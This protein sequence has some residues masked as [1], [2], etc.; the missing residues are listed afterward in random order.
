M[1]ICI[2]TISFIGSDLSDLSWR[3]ICS[4]PLESDYAQ[5]DLLT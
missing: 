5:L 3:W 4:I 1:H 2:S